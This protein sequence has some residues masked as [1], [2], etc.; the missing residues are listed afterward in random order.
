MKASAFEFRIR[1]LLHLIVYAL[2]FFAPWNYWL[3]IDPPGPNAHTWGIL[4]VALSKTGAV[5]I[6]VAFDLLLALGILF[7]IAGAFLRTWG[8]AYLGSG[9]V[10]D[11]AMHTS[12]AGTVI[13]DGP[14]RHLRNPLYVGT[15]LHTF[16]LALLMPASGAAFTIVAIGVMQ[17]RLM[18]GEESFLTANL[19][20]AYTAY[21]KLVPRI[22]PAI[23]AQV[24]GSGAQPAWGQA[25]LGETY[26]WCIALSFA[27]LGW[28]YNA[29]LLIQC[30]I[31]SVGLSFVAR[32]FTGVKKPAPSLP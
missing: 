16:A 26:F 20:T 23:R 17:V 29:S 21:C 15:F 28:R 27:A 3:H 25:F 7:A 32:A 22:V 1:Y 8:A 30:V 19:G 4:S 12:G 13:A 10:K 5:N 31:V 6:G 24:A 18:L 14:F 2:G 11:G 9:V